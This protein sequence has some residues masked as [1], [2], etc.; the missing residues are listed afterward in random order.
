MSFGEEL[1]KRARI[2]LHRPVEPARESHEISVSESA[3]AA[4]F[5]RRRASVRIA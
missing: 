4:R 2:E 1:A 5:P 3:A